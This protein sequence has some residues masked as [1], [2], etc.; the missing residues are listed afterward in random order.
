MKNYN[1]EIR[2]ARRILSKLGA[3]TFQPIIEN[4]ISRQA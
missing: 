1:L 3:N 2:K 4:K